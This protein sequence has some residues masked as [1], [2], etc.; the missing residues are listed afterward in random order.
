MVLQFVSVSVVLRK[1]PISLKKF[2]SCFI[3]N[4]QFANYIEYVLGLKQYPR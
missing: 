2:T 3:E 4:H 1:I